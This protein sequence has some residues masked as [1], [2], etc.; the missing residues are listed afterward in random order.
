MSHHEVEE[1]KSEVYIRSER[2][3]LYLYNISTVVGTHSAKER[4]SEFIAGIQFGVKRWSELTR[5]VNIRDIT[6][7]K[8]N[9]G[10]LLR[11]ISILCYKLV[12]SN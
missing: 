5:W 1:T 12:L 3:D 11:C 2:R 7:S 4:C 9:C 6:A 8:V 10:S